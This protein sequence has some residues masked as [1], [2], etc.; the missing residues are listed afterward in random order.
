M[1][2]RQREAGGLAGAGLCTGKQVTALEDRGDGLA[3]NRGGLCVA[4][5]GHG[6]FGKRHGKAIGPACPA[7]SFVR[8][9]WTKP[10]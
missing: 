3:L 5:F 10:G 7:H 9:S 6:E 4:E 1:Q 8:Q 2:Q